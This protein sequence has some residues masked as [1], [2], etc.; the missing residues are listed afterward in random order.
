MPDPLVLDVP[1]ELRLKLMSSVC[2]NGV[3][4]KRELLDRMVDEF[5]GV[6][7]VVATVDPQGSDSRRVIDGGIL[8][9]PDSMPV[10]G[11]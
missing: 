2:T 5:D 11:F 7:L 6:G 8:K 4:A 1:M 9:A 10:G 3:D